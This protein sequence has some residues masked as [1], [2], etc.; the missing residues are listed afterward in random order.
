LWWLPPEEEGYPDLKIRK[1]WALISIS[2]LRVPSL[3]K[4]TRLP[5]E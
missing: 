1:S 2:L 3:E 5:G 4:E